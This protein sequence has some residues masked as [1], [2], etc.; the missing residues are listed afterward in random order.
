MR[1]TNP[2][3]LLKSLKNYLVKCVY[4]VALLFSVPAVNK[5]E[6]KSEN[7]WLVHDLTLKSFSL[8]LVQIPTKF[9]HL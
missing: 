1:V 9:Q 5:N 4:S 3:K 2:R 7:Y 6:H 8:F